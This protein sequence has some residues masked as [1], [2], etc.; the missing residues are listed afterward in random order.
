MDNRFSGHAGGTMLDRLKTLFFDDDTSG[1]ASGRRGRDA[2]QLAAAALLVEAA[3]MDEAI[4][5]AELAQIRDLLS[6][7]F[8]LSS[9]EADELVRAAEAETEGPAQWH[10]F[11][12]TLKDRFSEAERIEMIE[13]LWEVVYADGNLHDLEA[14][15]LRRVGGLLYVSD[16]DRGAAR[17]RVLNRLGIGD[18]TTDV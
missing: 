17:L 5:P 1:A 14:S 2:V 13:M 11:T 9:A 7:R 6:R 4:G 18:P 12:S 3:R 10:R 15:L 16:R 8:G